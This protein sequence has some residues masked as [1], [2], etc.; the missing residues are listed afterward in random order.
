MH[1]RWS[2]CPVSVWSDTSLLISTKA[3]PI[4]GAVKWGT[5]I[6]VSNNSA[7]LSLMCGTEHR[8]HQTDEEWFKKHL[9]F[10]VPLIQGFPDTFLCAVV[11]MLELVP[12]AALCEGYWD[13]SSVRVVHRGGKLWQQWWWFH[14]LF[15]HSCSYSQYFVP[16][17]GSYCLRK[18]QH[19]Y[20]VAL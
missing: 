18:L 14:S 10:Q 1:G 19:V 11:K 20:T 16:S 5:G 12:R 13:S 15:I 8:E 7:S 3:L 2:A 17:W 4:P 6:L 9:C